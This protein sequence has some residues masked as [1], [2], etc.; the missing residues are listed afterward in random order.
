MA[1][2]QKKSNRE[3][4]KP[5]QDKTKTKTAPSSFLATAERN[6]PAGGGKRP[7]R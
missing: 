5:K 2:G 6:A 4:R 1:K 3:V 7:A